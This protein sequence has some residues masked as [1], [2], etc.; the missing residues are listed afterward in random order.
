[1]RRSLRVLWEGHEMP[2]TRATL[3]AL[4]DKISAKIHQV[5]HYRA[6]DCHFEH[7]RTIAEG[8]LLQ[9]N[10]VLHWIAEM[11]TAIP[12]TQCACIRGGFPVG[13]CV[14]CDAPQYAA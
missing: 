2:D 4:A 6:N 13:S 11:A 9:L 14:K 7:S 8:R 1:M 3:D 5:E 10:Q 12:P